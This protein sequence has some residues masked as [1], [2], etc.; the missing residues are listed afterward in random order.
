MAHQDIGGAYQV[1]HRATWHTC[2][3]D[4][5]TP[6]QATQQRAK[7]SGTQVDSSLEIV[8]Y[9]TSS[10][11]IH[12]A[13]PSLCPSSYACIAAPCGCRPRRFT[14]I[15]DDW[16]PSIPLRIPFRSMLNSACLGSGDSTTKACP[17]CSWG[18]GVFCPLGGWAD[19]AMR[20]LQRV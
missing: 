20:A 19:C 18:G 3:D 1:Y 7:F 13:C 12:T 4:Q 2:Q 5:I 8:S 16:S 15:R 11:S 6:Q 17:G 10:H 9:A 14:R